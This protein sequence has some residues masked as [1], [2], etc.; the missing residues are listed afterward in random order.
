M[1]LRATNSFM[2]RN[3]LATSLVV[4]TV[5]AAAA[6]LMVQTVVEGKS[7]QTIDTKRTSLFALFGLAY[8]GAYQFGI[9][10]KLLPRLL[11]GLATAPSTVLKRTLA[12]NLVHDPLVYFPV[13]YTM[14][15]TM[16]TDRLS[17][18]TVS[19]ALAFYY[20]NCTSDW[21]NTWVIWLPGHAVT[22]YLPPHL[23]MPWIASVSFVY[24]SVLS[25]TRGELLDANPELLDANPELLDAK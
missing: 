10:T 23:R 16:R 1:T 14:K 18:E 17:K 11:P 25:F 12:F 19:D 20:R 2:K 21:F 13:F 7:L 15:E 4:T 6:D 8:Q 3:P 24:L 5:K 9:I 22:F